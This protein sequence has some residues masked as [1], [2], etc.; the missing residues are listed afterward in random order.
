MGT[1]GKAGKGKELGRRAYM[2][3]KRQEQGRAMHG[4]LEWETRASGLYSGC[5]GARQ[6]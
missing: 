5:Q 3:G 2:E 4:A 1:E 6:V